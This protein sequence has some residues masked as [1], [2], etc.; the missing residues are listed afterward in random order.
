VPAE[1]ASTAPRS[2]KTDPSARPADL[3]E[4]TFSASA[5]N[6]LWLADLERHEALLDRAAMKG[7]RLRALAGVW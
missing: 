5:P 1:P 4:R 3:V 2:P 6:K 7:R